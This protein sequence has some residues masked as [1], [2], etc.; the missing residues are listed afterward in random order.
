MVTNIRSQC[1]RNENPPK[2][3]P[4]RTTAINK[5]VRANYLNSRKISL[6]CHSIRSIDPPCTNNA[7]ISTSNNAQSKPST[8]ALKGERLLNPERK[9][10]GRLR[11]PLP[12]PIP[13]PTPSPSRN[14]FQVS[15]VLESSANSSTS[16]TQSATTSPMT[17]PSS[18]SC[19]PTSFF[20][21]SHRNQP[22]DS[23]LPQ[24]SSS[25]PRFSRFRVTTVVESSLPKHKSLPDH[26]HQSD[27]STFHLPTTQSDQNQIKSTSSTSTTADTNTTKDYQ[28]PLAAS[29][30][31]TCSSTLTA[32]ITGTPPP[33]TSLCP[34]ATDELPTKSTNNHHL[35]H[36]KSQPELIMPNVNLRFTNTEIVAQQQQQHHS[37]TTSAPAL[38]PHMLNVTNVESAVAAR[39]SASPSQPLLAATSKMSTSFDSPDLEVKRFMDDSCSSISS[40]DSIRGDHQFMNTS[41]S[42]VDSCD[43]L[44]TPSS[45]R[46]PSLHGL[47]A[48]T[49]PAIPIF[50]D[51]TRCEPVVSS[52]SCGIKPIHDSLSSLET[53]TGSNDSLFE[54][55]TL[56]GPPPPSSSNEGTLTNSPVGPS[57][58]FTSPSPSS[59]GDRDISSGL[60]PVKAER[61]VRKTSWIKGD[62]G[63]PA[64]IDKLLSIFH[65]PGQFFTR[66]ST[67]TPSVSSA[68][69]TKREKDTHHH[70]DKPP[71][72]KESP[73]SGL[74]GWTSMSRKDHDP[75]P[76]VSCVSQSP[77]PHSLQ[78]PFQPQTKL[79]TNT[80]S[81]K[82]P[83]QPNYSPENTITTTAMSTPTSTMTTTTTVPS[84]TGSPDHQA[85]VLVPTTTPCCPCA[86]LIVSIPDRLQKEMK[87]NISPEHTITSST[88][89]S[90]KSQPQPSSPTQLSTTDAQPPSQSEIDAKTDRVHFELGG[91]DDDEDEE[92]DDEENATQRNNG[93]TSDRPSTSSDAS[94]HDTTDTM[95]GARLDVTNRIAG[96]G[97]ITR[98]SLSILHGEGNSSNSRDSM[99]SL[100][101]LTEIDN[102]VFR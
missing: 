26:L 51:K 92:E 90:V 20:S 99:R 89:M 44:G 83:L 33:P 77:P 75:C 72:R 50:I 79:Q 86:N 67:N 7:G 39:S 19:S 73:M 45:V 58:G 43:L 49:H 61:R 78:T 31:T 12:S 3:E 69:D 62:S 23:K 52:T 76:D 98:D 14:R 88:L 64:S 25:V 29:P 96:L 70:A 66:Q 41:T 95:K 46:Q 30:K 56:P 9:S 36:S 94:L 53:S 16:S 11:S 34:S 1:A 5:R 91:D 74:L 59:E 100:E 42:S 38:S 22:P 68:D 101:S 32:P 65:H 8:A 55:S 27:N 24:Q 4:V 85:A 57:S 6:T 60:S 17:P 10:A 35:P 47:A 48:K 2:P 15:R 87:E 28:Q 21:A 97:Q 93:T 40:I 102:N 81:I 71:S 63:Y 37:P 82:S 18:S 13:S 84:S 54:E 80:K